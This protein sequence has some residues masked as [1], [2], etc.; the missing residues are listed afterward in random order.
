MTHPYALSL[1]E[2]ADLIAVEGHLNTVL[3]EGHTGIGKSYTLKSLAGKF[4]T[5]HACYFDCTTKDVGDVMLPR[6]KDLDGQDYVRFATHEELGLHLA[7]RPLLLMIDELGKAVPGVINA[8]LRLM[9]ERQIGSYTL[10]PDSIVFA[11]TNIG[12]EGL[13]DRLLP[14]HR[15]RITTLRLRKPTNIEFIEWGINNGI[16]PT[17]LGWCRDNPQAFHSFEDYANPDDN[18]YIH[19]PRAANRTAFVTGRSLH[20]LSDVLKLRDKL[21]ETQLIASAIGK[22]G[23]R[24]ALDIMTFV[25]LADKLP[26]L[27]QIKETPETAPIPDSAAAVCL[28]CFR[29]LQTVERSWIDAW[30]TYMLRL[31]TEAQALFVNGVRAPGYKNAHMFATHSKFS[32]WALANGHLF[33]ADV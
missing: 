5:H 15:N 4:R 22:V 14:H 31:P 9:H 28:V 16:D 13:G 21:S 23:E 1:A 30:M 29:A 6:L 27:K 32:S 11:T 33:T 10:H 25:R 17:L 19:H 24:A 7:D 3:L 8:M 26:T 12:A 20:K 18:P 2:A